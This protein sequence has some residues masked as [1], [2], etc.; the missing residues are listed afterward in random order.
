MEIKHSIRELKIQ[1]KTEDKEIDNRDVGAGSF[2]LSNGIGGYL[3]FSEPVISKFNGCFVRIYED[4][5]GKE[6]N[7]SSELYKIIERIHVNGRELVSVDNHLTLIERNWQGN[8]DYTVFP[9]NI[10][11][12][13]YSL[14]NKDR[15]VI[16]WDFR[17]QND[18]SEF[19][20]NYEIFIEDGIIIIWFFKKKDANDKSKTEFELFAAIKAEDCDFQRD[21]SFIDK[22]EKVNYEYD[23]ERKDWPAER[24][25]YRPFVL[26]AKSLRMG[27]GKTRKEAIAE[28]EKLGEYRQETKKYEELENIKTLDKEI[29]A[30]FICS[31]NS[32]EKLSRN[33]NGVERM[34]AGYPWFTQMWSRDECVTLGAMIKSGQLEAVK[35]I[36]FS[37]SEKIDAEGRLPNFSEGGRTAGL[38]SADA[39]GWYWKRVSDFLNTLKK[40]K[41]FYNKISQK[42]ISELKKL[43]EFSINKVEENFGSNEGL[44]SNRKK[45]TW[46]DTDPEGKDSREGYR[47]E[48]QAMYLNMLNLMHSISADEKYLLKEQEVRKAV[49]KKFWNGSVLADGVLVD[50]VLTEDNRDATIRP[51]IFI[52]YYIYP[53]LLA[54]QEWTK[55]FKTTLERIWLEWGGVSTIDKNS[56]LFVREYSGRDDRS[57]HRGDSWYWLNNLTAI[58]LFRNDFN[59]F[60]QEIERIVKAS[61]EEIL[62]KGAIGSHAELSS[63]SHLSSKGCFLQAWSCSMYIEMIMEMCKSG[64][65]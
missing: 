45:E 48:I 33:I 57:Y 60:R 63:A 8:K 52:S 13:A 11:G 6:D 39:I 58:C 38:G 7:Q 19:G 10:N 31:Q 32:L 20:R 53:Q 26:E 24:Y 4:E 14:E 12:I 65:E 55:C 9:R 21:Y 36:L 17:K 47:I 3:F 18:L 16:D 51:N 37:Y 27:F 61:T 40:R 25:V 30:A 23:A 62:W 15:I 64:D 2:I 22:W 35:K 54:K 46:M 29:R 5:C 50:G 28:L 43:L 1:K 34:C 49:L 44:I 59:V 56:R 42:E 41:V